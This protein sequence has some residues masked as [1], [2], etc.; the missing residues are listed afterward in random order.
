[1]KKKH[2]DIICVT[3]EK[4]IIVEPS[5]N[6]KQRNNIFSKHK[7]RKI[8]HSATIT[9]YFQNNTIPGI[10]KKKYELLT[11][12]ITYIHY[13]DRTAYGNSPYLI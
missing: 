12:Y 8:K 10:K 7:L 4:N 13:L 2:N 3:Q 11:K 5:Q 6:P 9:V 1:M